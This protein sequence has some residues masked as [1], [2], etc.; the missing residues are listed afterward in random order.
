MDDVLC[1]VA[2]SS[3]E[4]APGLKL[5]G[6]TF[7]GIF[8]AHRSLQVD[9]YNRSPLRCKHVNREKWRAVW[10]K[11]SCNLLLATKPRHNAFSY[12]LFWW[13]K[14]EVSGCFENFLLL[15]RVRRLFNGFALPLVIISSNLDLSL[16][17]V[18]DPGLNTVSL[19]GCLVNF[20]LRT[21]LSLMIPFRHRNGVPSRLPPGISLQS[22]HLNYSQLTLLQ[23]FRTTYRR[24]NWTVVSSNARFRLRAEC[25]KPRPRDDV[26]P[27]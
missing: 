25:S 17:N 18:I 6:Y 9:R 26:R 20:F 21:S 8:T 3:I 7:L 5:V 23:I 10:S 13:C 16:Q 15:K 24:E 27:G 12:W 11:S 14:Q 4:F 2:R 1:F 22:C 19:P